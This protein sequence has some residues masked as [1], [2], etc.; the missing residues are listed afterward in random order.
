[1]TSAYQPQRPAAL[2]PSPAALVSIN[3]PFTGA[4]GTTLGYEYAHR[5]SMFFS[6]GS[7]SGNGLI[8][9]GP[10]IQQFKRRHAL[11][12]EGRG[13]GKM[14]SALSGSI[15][16]EHADPGGTWLIAGT[17][18]TRRYAHRKRRFNGAM[19]REQLSSRTPAAFWP[20][21]DWW[22]PR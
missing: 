9:A 1:M 17:T 8:V 6:I 22:F 4:P 12:P 7:A 11:L 18:R 15:S 13:Y 19:Q 2:T 14:R 16:L 21:T 10:D 3:D 5:I 20:G